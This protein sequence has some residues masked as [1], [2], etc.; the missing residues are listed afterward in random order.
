MLL[1]NFY[2][3]SE[4]RNH[5][6][7]LQAVIHIEAGHEIFKG[8]FPGQPVVPGVCMVQIVK[9]LLEACT[10]QQLFLAKGHQIKFLRLLV[11][12]R[13]DALQVNL[14]WKGEQGQYALTADFKKNQEAVFKLSGL[15][16]N[17][18]PAQV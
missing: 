17:T 2:T 13:E 5:A 16:T 6:N 18:L 7:Q 9:E 11:P 1:N 3:I 15:F 12:D 14:S 4:Q 10:G 8:H